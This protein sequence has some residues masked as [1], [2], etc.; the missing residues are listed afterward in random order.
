VLAVGPDDEARAAL[1][2]TGAAAVHPVEGREERISE[3]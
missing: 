1:E 2:A 3:Q